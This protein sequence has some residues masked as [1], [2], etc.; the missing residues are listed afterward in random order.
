M[1]NMQVNL[2][3]CVLC[4]LSDSL[5]QKVQQCLEDG[6]RLPVLD[7]KQLEL[8]N[9]ELVQQQDQSSRVEI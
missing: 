7:L 3:L 9:T 4:L 2:P 1:T 5:Q 8:E 6:V